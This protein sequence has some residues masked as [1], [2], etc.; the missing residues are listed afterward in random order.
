MKNKS[1]RLAVVSFVAVLGVFGLS[2]S[3]ADAARGSS[4]SARTG[5]G[6]CC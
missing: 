3:P 5:G 2:V 1:V 6:W 4:H